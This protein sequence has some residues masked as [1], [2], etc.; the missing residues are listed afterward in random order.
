MHVSMH[1]CKCMCKGLRRSIPSSTSKSDRLCGVCVC[2]YAPSTSFDEF[3]RKWNRPV[4]EFLLRHIYLETIV[5]Y[6]ASKIN[7]TAATLLFSLLLHE[8]RPC[9]SILTHAHTHRRPHADK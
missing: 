3:S 8:V 4:H 1:V 6:K 5:T 2:F 7:A 9:R